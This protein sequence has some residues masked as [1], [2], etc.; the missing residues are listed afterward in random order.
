MSPVC[1]K[2][3]EADSVQD[4]HA[5]IE[6]EAALVDPSR[7]GQSPLHDQ[8]RFEP[9]KLQHVSSSIAPQAV[10]EAAER[11]SGTWCL[12]VL[13]LVLIGPFAACA[14]H[15]RSYLSGEKSELR[16]QLSSDG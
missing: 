7:I 14:L 12:V 11:G 5:V 6:A 10:K 13:W 3:H 16:S 9:E 8:L 15:S 2:C 1:P 4:V